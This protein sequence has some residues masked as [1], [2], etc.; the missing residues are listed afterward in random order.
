MKIIEINGES[1]EAAYITSWFSRWSRW[2][3]RSHWSLSWSKDDYCGLCAPH[4]K[5]NYRLIWCKNFF[6]LL[7]FAESENP[8][9]IK[10]KW[11]DA[12]VYSHCCQ[13]LH[14]I[15][16]IQNSNILMHSG[17]NAYS[18]TRLSSLS[19]GALETLWSLLKWQN[20][21]V[22]NSWCNHTETT[23]IL[24]PNQKLS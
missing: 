13:T 21:C 15:Y 20:I 23:W 16:Q 14:Q 4:N 5:T 22:N 18:W 1:F 12:A 2:S 11:S 3:T 6:C 8:V 17:I 19:R 10:W 7:D 24:N 9:R